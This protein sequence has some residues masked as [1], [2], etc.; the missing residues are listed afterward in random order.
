M[1]AQR[2]VTRYAKLAAA[3]NRATKRQKEMREEILADVKPVAVPH[4]EEVKGE[5]VLKFTIEIKGNPLPTD[6][7]YVLNI[8]AQGGREPVDWRQL[9]EDYMTKAL[10]K[11]YGPTVARVVAKDKLEAMA[12]A[13]PAKTG[14]KIEGGINP[15]Y[16]VSSAPSAVKV[17]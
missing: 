10:T 6:G 16:R 14:V 3:I 17:A 9:L 1:I 4:M 13:S 12:L 15:S 2:M 7:P 11:K 5:K 8:S